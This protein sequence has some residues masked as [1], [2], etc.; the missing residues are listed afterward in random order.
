M[1]WD[2]P[3][4]PP[5][6]LPAAQRPRWGHRSR[7]CEY[8]KR[9]PNAAREAET[10]HRGPVTCVAPVPDATPVS[11][12]VIDCDPQSVIPKLNWAC[13]PLSVTDDGQKGAPRLQPVSLLVSPSVELSA[14][15]GLRQVST[16]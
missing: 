3:A 8:L 7:Y 11:V 1:R 5:T 10:E 9:T 16:D 14:L 12:R 2:R 13:P 6:L 4:W 15:V